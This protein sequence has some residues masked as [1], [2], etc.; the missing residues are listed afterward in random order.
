MTDIVIKKQNGNI[1]AVDCKGHSG[2]AESGS[3][4]V[5]AAISAVVQTALLGLLSVVKVSVKY[6]V[7]EEQGGLQ[8]ELPSMLTE[9]ENHDAQIVLFTMLCGLT[10]I[11]TEYSDYMNLEVIEQCL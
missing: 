3:D 9:S 6:R 7:D 8:I 1:I 2:Y 10:D 5:C 4:I 11:N